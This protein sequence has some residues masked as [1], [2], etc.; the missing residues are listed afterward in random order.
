MWVGNL[1]LCTAVECEKKNKKKTILVQPCRLLGQTVFKPACALNKKR[2]YE[3]M[4][5]TSKKYSL[6]M[7]FLSLF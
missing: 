1:E 2:S 7:I 5:I 6:E 3:Y 4:Y